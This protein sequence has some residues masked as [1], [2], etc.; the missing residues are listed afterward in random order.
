MILLIDV[1][2]SEKTKNINEKE[3][4]DQWDLYGAIRDIILSPF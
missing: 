4:V 2:N 1:E 3:D